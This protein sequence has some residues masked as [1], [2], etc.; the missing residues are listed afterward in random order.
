MYAPVE[1]TSV[2]LGWVRFGA[3]EEEEKEKKWNRFFVFN[4]AARVRRYGGTAIQRRYRPVARTGVALGLVRF[5]AFG[6]RKK[7]KC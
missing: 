3:I 5:G 4:M 6:T 7:E 1:R 2:V